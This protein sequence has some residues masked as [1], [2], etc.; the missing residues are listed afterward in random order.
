MTAH[1]LWALDG[2]HLTMDRT[3]LVDGAEP[4]PVTFPAPSF[5][6]EHDGGL[7]L[8]DTGVTPVAAPDPGK[9]FGEAG[10]QITYD[11][12][13]RVDRQLEQLGVATSDVTHVVLSH[14][15]FDHTGGLG[16]FAQARFLVGRGELPT[17]FW[18]GPGLG[19][20]YRHAD[21]DPTR[22][23]DWTYL[24]AELDLFDDGGLVVLPMPGHT[25]GNLALL[26]RLPQR[27]ILLT[28]DTAHLREA[29][30]RL[31]PME[32]D[33]D[34]EAAVRSLEAINRIAA[35]NDAEVWVG[36]DPDDWQ[37]FGAPGLIGRP[38]IGPGLPAPDAAR[39][40]AGD[41]SSRSES[42]SEPNPDR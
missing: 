20:A 22:R 40:P 3:E 26:V 41:H 4:G 28:G 19:G 8:F 18:P 34:Q 7:V 9:A 42:R 33:A 17:A 21:L 2:A 15:H 36:H 29:L 5:L 31:A 1:R 23:F 13:Q 24:D 38:R 30:E 16:L 10:P 12:S 25:P 27:T 6:V 37:R 39:R 35:E 14:A 11:V 32:A